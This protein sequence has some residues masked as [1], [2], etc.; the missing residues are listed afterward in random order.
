MCLLDTYMF[1]FKKYL[2]CSSFQVPSACWMSVC[3]FPL[4]DVF[5][6]TLSLN[7]VLLHQHFLVCRELIR[8]SWLLLPV[9]LDYYHPPHPHTPPHQCLKVL[10]LFSYSMVSDLRVSYIFDLGWTWLLVWWEKRI[11][12][13]SSAQAYPF[14][15]NICWRDWLFSHY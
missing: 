1:H 14:L 5:L 13:H 4:A 6:S 3:S 10:A 2:W 9:C 7:F 8:L 15:P 12:F 11:H